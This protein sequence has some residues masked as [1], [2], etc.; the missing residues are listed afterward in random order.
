MW[1]DIFSIPPLHARLLAMVDKEDITD[2]NYMNIDNEEDFAKVGYLRLLRKSVHLQIGKVYMSLGDYSKAL[3]TL[4]NC[5]ANQSSVSG[6][7][8][9]D[10]VKGSASAKWV[11]LT[12]RILRERED[13]NKKSRGKI[14]KRFREVTSVIGH[15]VDFDDSDFDILH[16]IGLSLFKFG[17]RPQAVNVFKAAA[18]R[19]EANRGEDSVSRLVSC[20]VNVI[21][22]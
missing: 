7:G 3:D 6:G 11:D 10:G 9:G 5:F 4:S 15:Q 8:G 1:L 17:N 12:K 2:E 16:N 21:N 18:T 22:G 13:A 20:I 14:S 19:A